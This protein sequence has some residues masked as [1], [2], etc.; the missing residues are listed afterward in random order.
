MFFSR[1]S[2]QFPNLVLTTWMIA[3]TLLLLTPT[4]Y[5]SS[6][7]TWPS[8]WSGEFTY[9]SETHGVN[10]TTSAWMGYSFTPDLVGWTWVMES[11]NAGHCSIYAQAEGISDLKSTACLLQF[12]SDG[13]DY[14]ALFPNGKEEHGVCCY[15]NNTGVIT[16]D[17]LEPFA[18]VRSESWNNIPANLYQFQ[19]NQLNFLY[20]ADRADPSRPAQVKD[21]L[22][23][24]TVQPYNAFSFAPNSIVAKPQPPSV[25]LRPSICDAA[26]QCPSGIDL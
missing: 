23:F 5:G 14:L 20:L 8:G 4:T 22:S 9:T 24:G 15:I 13:N 18:F 7:L 16:R 19:A 2:Q 1:S 6:P 21:M 11:S 10:E 3:C 17:W 12:A 26:P 25:F